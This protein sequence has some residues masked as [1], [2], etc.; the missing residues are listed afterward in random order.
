MAVKIEIK[1]LDKIAKMADKYPAI[2]Q[3]HIDKAIVRSIGEIDIQTKPFTPVKTGRLRS[4]MLPKFSPFQGIYGSK[5]PYAIT[6][7]DKYGEG[8]VK[9]YRHPSLN[10]KAISSFLFEGARKSE[11]VINK[12][13]Q[14]ALDN[15]AEDLV[16]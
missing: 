12:E 2:S 5:L 4:S 8:V 10:K 14:E 1:N 13:F 15:I 11:K 3:R 7:H 9:P 6:V 16:K